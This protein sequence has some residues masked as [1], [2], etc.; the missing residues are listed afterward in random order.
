MMKRAKE[1]GIPGNIVLADSAYRRQH[2]VQKLGARARLRLC[3]RFCVVRVQTTQPSA[4]SR[5][6]S[7]TQGLVHQHSLHATLLSEFVAVVLLD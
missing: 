2:G 5:G 1:N 4:P 6:L 7:A 3:S